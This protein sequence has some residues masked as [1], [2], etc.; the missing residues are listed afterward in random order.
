M[1]KKRLMILSILSLAYQ[2]SFF[3]IYWIK[4]DLISLDPIMADI[5]WLTAGLFGVILGMYALLI[6]RALDSSSLVA[7]ITFIIGILTL[8]LL[9]LAALVTSM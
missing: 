5:Y 1:N 3:H 7:I 6:Y 9:I 8:G 2:Y 4:D